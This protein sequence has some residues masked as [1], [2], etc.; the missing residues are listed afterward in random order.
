MAILFAGKKK[1]RVTFYCDRNT[2]IYV[3]PNPRMPNF[4]SFSSNDNA[5]TK[6]R[7]RQ[8]DE[9]AQG[10]VAMMMADCDSRYSLPKKPVIGANLIQLTQVEVDELYNIL[11]VVIS[12]LDDI[13]VQYVVIKGSLLG[14]V[15]SQ[16]ILLCEHDVDIAIIDDGKDSYSRFLKKLPEALN[17]ASTQRSNVTDKFMTYD[18]HQRSREGCDRIMSSDAPNVWLDVFVLRKYDSA[19]ELVRTFDVNFQDADA[20]SRL[21]DDKCFLT[22]KFPLYHYD[23]RNAIELWPHQH[24]S[25][26]EL[27]PLQ[28]LKFGPLEVLAPHET[29]LTLQRFY[30]NDVFTQHHRRMNGCV[31][32]S[33]TNWSRIDKRPLLQRQSHL[34]EHSD[35][36]RWAIDSRMQQ[37]SKIDGYDCEPD[38]ESCSDGDD[39]QSPP[40]ALSPSIGGG[41]MGMA[42]SKSLF[43]IKASSI[44][45]F[46]PPPLLPS[47]L[48]AI[49]DWD[50]YPREPVPPKSFGADLRRYLGEDP[51]NP[52]FNNGVRK[53]MEPHLQTA[54]RD[55]QSIRK[56]SHLQ[57]DAS[58]AS[59]VGIPYTSLRDE[60]RFLFDEHS[61]P[62][63]EVLSQTLG[64][65]N[66]SLL[67]EH[68][69][70]DLVQLLAPLLSRDSRRRFHACYDSLV[71][72]FC[73]PL[74][75][76]IAMERGLFH[77][78]TSNA[79]SK[80]MYRYQAFP[81][82]SIV[83]PGEVSIG[84]HCDTGKFPCSSFL[85][86]FSKTVL[87]M[88]R[89]FI[90]Q[91]MVT[92][93]E[94]STFTFR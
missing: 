64:I 70:Q 1:T 85:V 76:S 19:N 51:K 32:D 16:S 10:V 68:P 30:D 86:L 89:V 27:F 39:D 3:F 57:V 80:V 84:P 29:I 92:R 66:L 25:P 20:D 37:Q 88:Q 31:P 74:L 79:S 58:I 34:I 38:L 48:T 21:S 82:L 47:S 69:V 42:R 75:H 93:W 6:A 52:D 9:E 87:T 2:K 44:G 26:S 24:F 59:Y 43:S 4:H 35:Q 23:N 56:P 17:S 50:G 46:L 36:G 11:S 63:H 73:I 41:G 94:I 13:D 54:R 22:E 71:T 5:L 60:R 28:R 33:R 61:Y 7:R 67:H 8:E 62:I 18:F 77:T 72:G 14:A 91:L 15:R 81:C 65:A 12:L 49:H 45:L 40:R 53:Y 90:L 78:K 83:R 55:R